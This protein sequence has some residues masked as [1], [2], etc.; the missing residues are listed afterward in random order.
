MMKTQKMMYMYMYSA[1]DV[2]QCVCLHLLYR[3]CAFTSEPASEKLSYTL[4]IG[5]ESVPPHFMFVHLVL[6]TLGS[7]LSAVYLFCM[8]A[9]SLLP[10]WDNIKLSRTLTEYKS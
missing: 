4:N 7:M 6:F 8:L 2:Y 3:M 9:A 5:F 10:I 1:V